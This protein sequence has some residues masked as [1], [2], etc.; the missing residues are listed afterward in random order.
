MNNS[1][2]NT[3][4][5]LSLVAVFAFILLY[6]PIS[7]FAEGGI[8]Y[9]FGDTSNYNYQNYNPYGY[10]NN[11]YQPAVYVEPV[12]PASPATSAPVNQDPITIYSSG[13]NPDAQTPT[14]VSKPKP[15]VVASL[16]KK[17]TEY[18]LAYVPVD[19]LKSVGAIRAD[20]KSV[21]SPTTSSNMTA[22]V[23]DSTASFMPS[24][25]IGW[26][27]FAIMLLIII[28]LIRKIF[29]AEAAY[30]AAPMKHH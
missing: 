27:L 2:K 10:S 15:K 11:G 21:T 13:V 3:I 17:A 7:S 28:I 19:K 5:T 26:I 16:P 9:S 14:P 30:H 22:N 24:G 12:Y 29:G 20:S 18:A 1:N 23:I 6:S 25:I 4:K 8:N